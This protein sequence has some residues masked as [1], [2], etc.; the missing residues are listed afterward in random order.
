MLI[1]FFHVTLARVSHSDVP[2]LKHWVLR[3]YYSVITCPDLENQILVNQANN[4]TSQNTPFSLHFVI[5]NHVSSSS[6]LCQFHHFFKFPWPTFLKICTSIIDDII[7]IKHQRIKKFSTFI[8]Q[9]STTRYILFCISLLQSSHFPIAYLSKQ[10]LTT[11]TLLSPCLCYYLPG[12]TNNQ[13][14][15]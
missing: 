1:T 8:A 6:Y 11:P 7:F 10:F 3:E 13:T 12:K 4:F 5:L 14:K 15:K 9:I 2:E